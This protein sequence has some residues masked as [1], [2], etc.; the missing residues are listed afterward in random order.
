MQGQLDTA[1]PPND[2]APLLYL[3]G[4]PVSGKIENKMKINYVRRRFHQ[5]LQE[6]YLWTSEQIDGVDWK[7]HA[8]ALWRLPKAQRKTIQKFIH[9]W[10]PTQNQNRK[11]HGLDDVNCKLCKTEIDDNEHFLRCKHKAYKTQ[12]KQTMEELT[13]MLDGLQPSIKELWRLTLSADDIP[14]TTTTNLDYVRQQIN[15]GGR[16]ILYGRIT[17]NLVLAQLTYM[18]SNSTKPM[19]GQQYL[20]KIVLKTWQAVIKCWHQKLASEGKR[21]TEHEILLHKARE[22]YNKHHT[23]TNYQ[24]H[25]PEKINQLESYTS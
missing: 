18:E 21:S 17:K 10:L 3:D 11:I 20:T 15:L 14:S 19:N 25:F 24:S 12:R 16:Q 2:L 7:I 4:K 9:G 13:E 23:T 22:L 1:A 6:R 8:R 5:R